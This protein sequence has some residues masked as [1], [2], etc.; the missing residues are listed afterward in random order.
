M[1]NRRVIDEKDER[2]AMLERQLIELQ[3][4]KQQVAATVAVDHNS[5]SFSLPKGIFKYFLRAGRLKVILA[6]TILVL[7]FITAGGIRLFAGNASKQNIIT[8][9]EHVQ[10][11]ATLATA[12]AY[13]TAVIQEEDNKI[14]S[15]D[16]SIN[17][18]GTKRELLF[19]VPGTVI[20]GVN[21]EGITSRD[22]DINEKTKEI[23]ITL[24]R[25]ELLQE[26]SLTDG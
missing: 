12:K 18:P 7:L 13:T 16:I 10:E 4:A 23:D 14:F 26:A 15:K 21:L 11:L 9:V 22:M 17:L 24:P 8:I 2:I 6:I 25:A 20:A 5:S 1:E 19:I 3:E